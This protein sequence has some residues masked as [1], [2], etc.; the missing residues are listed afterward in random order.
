MAGTAADAGEPL[1]LALAAPVFAAPGY[2]TLRT[3]SLE[4]ASW[5]TVRR[6]VLRA[7]ELGF[8]SAWF[9]DHLFHGRDGAFFESWTA[10]CV[11]AGATSRIRLVN[12]HL[13]NGLRDARVLAKMA[14]TLAAITEGRFDLFLATGYREREYRAYGLP[15]E[16]RGVRTRRLA[17]ALKTVRLLWPGRPVGAEGEFYPLRDAVAAPSYAERPFV[18]LGGPLDEAMRELVAAEA[19][20]WNSFPLGLDEYREAAARVDAACDAIGR[21]PRSLRRSLETQVLVLEDASDWDRWLDRWRSLRAA[22]PLGPAVDDL[23]PAPEELGDEFL[24]ATCRSR[25][26][27]GTRAEVARTV[28]AYRE[29][30]VTDLV[31]WFMDAPSDASMTALAEIVRSSQ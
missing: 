8:D 22:L 30:G 11:A 18:W 3:P 6:L 10:L 7:E 21:N 13:G 9:S 14:T 15:W 2:P 25:F 5:A 23:V 1:R 12:N 29:A 28:A 19:D 17:E 20:G 27:V 4:A 31:C 16:P 26:I 24:T